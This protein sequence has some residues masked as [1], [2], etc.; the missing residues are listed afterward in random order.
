VLETVS[1][2]TLVAQ[3]LM[4]QEMAHVFGPLSFDD[5]P[6]FILEFDQLLADANRRQRLSARGK[7]LIDGQ[8]AHRVVAAL[9]SL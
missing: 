3:W 5:G 9:L 8:G 1:N 2:Q 7:D 4:E 6:R